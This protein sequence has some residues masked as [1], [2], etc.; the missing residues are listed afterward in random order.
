MFCDVSGPTEDDE[1]EAGRAV[2]TKRSRVPDAPSKV[3]DAR[4]FANNEASRARQ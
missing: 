1:Q 4:R 2:L 3:Y